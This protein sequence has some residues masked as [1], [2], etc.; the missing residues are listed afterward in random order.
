MKKIF[1][2]IVVG[3]LTFNSITHAD[4]ALEETQTL[5]KENQK[6]LEEAEAQKLAIQL[7]AIMANEKTLDTVYEQL[8][9]LTVALSGSKEE[10][11]TE[12]LRAIQDA[13]A[14]KVK[15]SFISNYAKIYTVDELKGLVE[16]YESPLGKTLLEKEPELVQKTMMDLQKH[17]VAIMPQ[18][19]K[20][21]QQ[22][23]K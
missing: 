2:A 9:Q 14:G 18:L 8:N 7:F 16:F 10:F 3:I 12:S 11:P 6:K 22:N 21:L 19:E 1:T 4:S 23:Q 17:I 15:Q 5:L 13:I 20:Q